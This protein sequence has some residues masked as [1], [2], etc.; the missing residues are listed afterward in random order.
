M[1]APPL[2]AAQTTAPANG[3]GAQGVSAATAA[4]KRKGHGPLMGFEALL[5][6]LSAAQGE[7]TN[8]TAAVGTKPGAATKEKAEAEAKTAGDLAS[9]DAKADTSDSAQAATAAANPA[10]IVSLPQVAPAAPL[11]QAVEPSAITSGSGGGFMP[12]Q[13]DPANTAA[14]KSAH[15]RAITNASQDVAVPGPSTPGGFEIA[16]ATPGEQRPAAKADTSATAQNQI[17]AAGPQPSAV[18]ATPLPNPGTAVQTTATD[19]AMRIAAATT[20]AEATASIQAAEQAK[21]SVTPSASPGARDRTSTGK[22]PR[23]DGVQT[24]VV[25]SSGAAISAKMAE[26]VQSQAETDLTLAG[27]APDNSDTSL[28]DAERESQPDAGASGAEGAASSQ[29]TTTPATVIHSEPAQVRALPQTVASLAAQIV[30]KLDGRS[31][32]FD[33]ALDPVGL[34]HV[35]VR[36]VIGASGKVSAALAFDTPQAA[37]ELRGRAGELHAALEKAGFDLSG[38]LTFD[39]AGDRGQGQGSAGQD[40]R[41]TPGFHGQAFQSALDTVSAVA[42]GGG[43][44]FTRSPAAGVDIRI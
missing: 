21:S 20:A 4:A 23:A 18:P 15:A 42:A 43:L 6:M 11:P 29:A 10:L 9:N 17:P 14:S 16:A 40:G 35:S 19:A 34:G 39:V 13:D 3:T 25:A 36:V 1:S 2:D 5:A 22:P 38:G 12:I 33:V 7:T 24:G 44:A 32:H 8:E 37:A 30:K 27:P 41:T 31:S 26:A 28:L